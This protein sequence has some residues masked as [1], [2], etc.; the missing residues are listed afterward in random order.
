MHLAAHSEVP[1]PETPFSKVNGPVM[2]YI[3][4]SA[5][6]VRLLK[7]SLRQTCLARRDA[8]D[9]GAR[10]RISATVC[11]ALLAWLD[12]R[13]RTVVSAFWPIRSEL[14]LR[15]L[16]AEALARG[17]LLA[18]PRIDQGRLTFRAFEGAE[19]ELV[20]GGFGTR[21]P[22]AEAEVRDPT[23]VLVPLAAF[24]RAGG[25]IGY[26][27]GY[28]DAALA[29]L[30]TRQPFTSVACAFETQRVDHVPMEPH[31]WRLDWIATEEGLRRADPAAS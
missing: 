14:D 22:Q 20:D 29:E 9:E 21:V 26:G 5:H 24:D 31:D 4:P 12:G 27:K 19:E 23:L 17:H 15:P 10:A 25:R 7:H 13:P 28:Y 2:T 30:A 6:E 8:L 16:M 1:T 18:L 11:E 3:P